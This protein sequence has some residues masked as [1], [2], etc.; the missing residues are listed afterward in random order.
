MRFTVD[1]LVLRLPGD[2]AVRVSHTGR[3]NGA[4]TLSDTIC[5]VGLEGRY[6]V[7]R[8]VLAADAGATTVAA[9]GRRRLS[10]VKAP[11]TLC[12]VF[13]RRLL[14]RGGPRSLVRCVPVG[15]PLAAFGGQTPDGQG[16]DLGRVREGLDASVGGMHL[17]GEGVE[18]AAGL[19]ERRG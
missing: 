1:L 14:E 19:G 7:V 15:G 16:A 12:F 2:S 8:A 9:V 18:V 10:A 3:G 5:W 13:E 4:E 17:W 6:E 11:P